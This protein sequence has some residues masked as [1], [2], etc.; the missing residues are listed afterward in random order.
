MNILRLSTLSLTIILF[1]LGALMLPVNTT[2]AHHCKGG[3]RTPDC[4]DGGGTGTQTTFTVTLVLTALSPGSTEPAVITC[5]GTTSNSFRSVV[6]SHEVLELACP[7]TVTD[8]TFGPD[9]M[10]V[11]GLALK[12]TKKRTEV[13]LFFRLPCDALDS[14]S[15][16]WETPSLPAEIV[17]VSGE[18]FTVSVGAVNV[19]LTKNQEP[20]KGTILADTIDVVTVVYTAD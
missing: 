7:V 19:A 3:H 13:L 9:P 8:P 11:G 10:C 18:N 15:E 20:F 17:G 1:S 6:F 4:L 14:G 2:L 5:E 12:K 16:T